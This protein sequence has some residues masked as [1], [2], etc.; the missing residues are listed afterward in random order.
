MRQSLK[1]TFAGG[2]AMKLRGFNWG[3]H[4][5]SIERSYELEEILFRI[6][7]GLRFPLRVRLRLVCNV[8]ARR[9][10]GSGDAFATRNRPKELLRVACAWSVRHGILFH[11][12]VRPVHAERE[13]RHRSA[14]RPAGGLSVR[15]A[16]FD[17]VRRPT[18]NI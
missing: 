2:L 17:L 6:H 5:T 15:R 10:S 11:A 1:S 3:P 14:P 8:N 12:A 9:A 4:Q 16:T 7:R 13:R 18:I